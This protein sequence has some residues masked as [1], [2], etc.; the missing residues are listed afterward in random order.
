MG[1]PTSGRLRHRV[2]PAPPAAWNPRLSGRA[3][4]RELR[5]S[6]C[7]F[8]LW[9]S[10][11]SQALALR[12]GPAV[13][14]QPHEFLACFVARSGAYFAPRVPTARLQTGFPLLERQDERI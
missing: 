13:L 11:A 14:Q 10:A 2:A 8:E 12:L 9:P 7:C 5:P 6:S 1:S 4:R 3:R